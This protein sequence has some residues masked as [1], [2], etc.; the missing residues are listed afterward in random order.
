MNHA[1]HLATHTATTDTKAA[2]PAQNGYLTALFET[3]LEVIVGLVDGGKFP[4]PGTQDV[5][6]IGQARYKSRLTSSSATDSSRVA[7]CS[8]RSAVAAT[9]QQIC[10][11]ELLSQKRS[12]HSSLQASPFV[13][14]PIGQL[15]HFLRCTMPTCCGGNG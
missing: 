5:Y 12:T 7:S 13:A 11:I 1:D 4:L 14:R 15:L 2:R 8:G 3:R 9:P 6:C 10:F